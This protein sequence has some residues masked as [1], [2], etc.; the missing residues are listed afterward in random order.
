M[1]TE[2]FTVP[3]D[4]EGNVQLTREL[5]EQSGWQP[6]MKLEWIDNGDGT[7]TLFQVEEDDDN[8]GE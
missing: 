5:M 3:V 7:V 4:G 1:T 6:G 2:R 8:P